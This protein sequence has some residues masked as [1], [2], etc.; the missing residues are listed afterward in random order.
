MA[1]L[2]V[3]GLKRNSSSLLN[4]EFKTSKLKIEK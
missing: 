3:E 4:V 1:F 2:E